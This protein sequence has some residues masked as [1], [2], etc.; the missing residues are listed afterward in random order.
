MRMG[1]EKP[2]VALWFQHG[3]R[4]PGAVRKGVMLRA[5]AGTVGVGGGDVRVRGCLN[6]GG[7]GGRERG[8]WAQ[9]EWGSSFGDSRGTR[10]GA[11]RGG[12]RVG[13]PA[14]HF[15][16]LSSS[17]CQD[18]VSPVHSPFPI[19]FLCTSSF[20]PSVP[21]HPIFFLLCPSSFLCILLSHQFLLLSLLPPQLPHP[22]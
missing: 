1:L 2:R 11:Q 21:F 18:P 5:E 13:G 20:S 14:G 3:L 8:E 4:A 12:V 9:W 22:P 6:V 10:E 16:F 19:V 15:C 17:V 7:L